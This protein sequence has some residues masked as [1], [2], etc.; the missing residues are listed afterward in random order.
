MTRGPSSLD[1]AGTA[2][3]SRVR[4]RLTP[5]QDAQSTCAGLQADHSHLMLS[6]GQS[7][8]V[9]RCLTPV[10]QIFQQSRR[11]PSWLSPSH[12]E[13]I[14][15]LIHFPGAKALKRPSP[16]KQPGSPLMPPVSLEQFLCFLVFLFIHSAQEEGGCGFTRPCHL[17][18]DA[19]AR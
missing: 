14:Q 3:G 1:S 7:P 2:P 19:D 6:S 15:R 5:A 12:G 13:Y 18:T 4:A 10:P 11:P 17:R 9:R 8:P 16:K